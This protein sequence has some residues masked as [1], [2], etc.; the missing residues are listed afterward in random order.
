METAEHA[1]T[2]VKVLNK[3]TEDILEHSKAQMNQLQMQKREFYAD[4]F[5]KELLEEYRQEALSQEYQL[6]YELPPK[7]LILIDPDRIAQVVQNIVSN[8]VKYR[9]DRCEI[10]VSFEIMEQE[11]RI[12]VISISDNG[13]GI[14]AADIPFVFDLF[15]RGNKAR[16]QN[17][18]GSGIGLNISKY[19]VEQHGGTMECD[20]VVGVGTTISFSIPIL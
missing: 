9:K 10:Q 15:Y 6:T 4:A 16:T 3:L 14:E 2:K 1:L 17:V 11:K 19:I 18:P 12:L 13:T 20:S 5:F 7:V 8:A